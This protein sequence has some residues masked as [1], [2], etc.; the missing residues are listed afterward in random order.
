[1]VLQDGHSRK[2][3]QALVGIS[4]EDAWPHDGQVK[5]LVS[6]GALWAEDDMTQSLTAFQAR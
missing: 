3:T 1:M 6:V 2:N 5:R 4:W